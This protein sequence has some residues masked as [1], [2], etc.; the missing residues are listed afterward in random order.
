MKIKSLYIVLFFAVLWL[1]ALAQNKDFGVWT[2]VKVSKDITKEWK[3]IGEVQSRFNQNATSWAS[4]YFQVESS[5][6]VA[7]FYKIAVAYRFTNRAEAAENRI[8]VD[9]NFKYKIQHNSFQ[10]RLKY[11]NS[12][13]SS[14]SDEQRIRVRFKYSYKVNKKFK[15]YLKAQYFYTLK[16]DYSDWDQQR[17]GIG[18]LLRVAKRNYVDVFYNFDFE[19]NVANPDAKYILG[20]KYKLELK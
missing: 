2:G 10:I 12:F 14:G 3:I 8:D 17:Y 13:T 5:Y 6:K 15:P 4:N 1:P 20:V 9:Q 11:Q 7:K 19:K 18:T 16:N